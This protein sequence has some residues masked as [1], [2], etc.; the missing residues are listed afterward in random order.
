MKIVKYV[1]VSFALILAGAVLLFFPDKSNDTSVDVDN[2]SPL[3]PS[4]DP[5]NTP[6]NEAE[7]KE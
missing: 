7:N 5:V 4:S 3:V 6:E 1:L 2:D